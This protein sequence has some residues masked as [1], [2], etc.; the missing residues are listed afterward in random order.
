MLISIIPL[1][2]SAW[3]LLLAGI[4]VANVAMADNWSYWGNVSDPAQVTGSLRAHIATDGTNFYY[5]T[6]ADGIFRADLT[7]RTFT[8]MPTNGL[9][10]CSSANTNALT[11]WNLAVSPRGTVLVGAHPT[12]MTFQNN[13]FAGIAQQSAPNTIPLIYYFDANANQWQPATINGQSYPYKQF[14]GNFAFAS[15]GTVWTCSGFAPYVYKSTDDGHSYTAFDLDERVPTNYFS[16]LGGQTSLGRMFSVVVGPGDELFAGTETAGFLHSQDGGQTWTSLDPH[17]ADTNSVNPLGRV[18]NATFG[19]LDRFGNLLCVATEYGSFPGINVWSGN[20]LVGYHLADGT[21]FNA[22][23]G[24]PAYS[25]TPFRIYTTP[26]GWSLTE[27][28]QDDAGDGGV[29]RSSDGQN[30]TQFNTGIPSLDVPHLSSNP[31]PGFIVDSGDCLTMLGTQIFVADSQMNIWV[32][33]TAPLPVTNHPPSALPQNLTLWQ[34]EATNITL[35]G[36]DAD[37]NSLNFNIIA[38]PQWGTLTGTPPNLTYVP[39]FYYHGL[40]QFQFA[41]D[42]GQATSTVATVSIT[43]NEL[44]ATEPAASWLSPTNLTLFVGPTNFT[45]LAAASDAGGIQEMDFWDGT[46]F[47]GVAGAA[48]FFFTYTNLAVGT[49]ELSALAINHAG[50]TAWT[51]PT[52]VVVVAGPLYLAVG[53]GPANLR[54][55]NWP[56]RVSGAL[57]ESAPSPIGPWSLVPNPPVDL[58]YSLHSVML[59]NNSAAGFFRLFL[60]P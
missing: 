21:Y 1:S 7:N 28:D 53:T 27:M 56:L 3:R 9:N 23:M 17:F 34:N 48:P 11:V 20:S 5:A 4:F 45:T 29:Y 36:T 24:L 6:L 30:W 57:L 31:K 39:G 59:T 42:D 44:A 55:V 10:L 52:T 60:A 58:N 37:G 25:V 12:V 54:S 43:V 33:D 2:K 15:D 14:S 19:G 22:S 18:G 13:S 49:H 16:V 47:D 38:Q 35:S 51:A 32:Y 46:N 8:A 26:A 41:V 40:D 50:G